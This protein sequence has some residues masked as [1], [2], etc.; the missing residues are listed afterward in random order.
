MN[1]Q[2]YICGESS[3]DNFYFNNIKRCNKEDE[4]RLRQCK[5]DLPYRSTWLG[6][7]ILRVA[8]INNNIFCGGLLTLP[9]QGVA[10]AWSFQSKKL[11]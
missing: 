11:K 9:V 1:S 8:V 6:K 5:V 7:P 10:K 4:N 3:R 2:N